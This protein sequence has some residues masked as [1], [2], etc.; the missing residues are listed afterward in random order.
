MKIGEHDNTFET[1]AKVKSQDFSV[2]NS[3]K[4]IGIL[5]N[6]LYEHKVR[7]MCQ[8]IMCNGRDALREIKSNKRI[9]VSIPNQMSP[10][11]KVKDFGPGI[12][13]DRMANVFIRYG[14]STKDE[15]NE[16]TGGLGIGAKSPFAYTDS[17]TIISITD[18]KKRTY[19]AHIGVNSQGRL[20]LIST[21]ETDEQNGTEINVAVKPGDLNEF[22]TSIY[23]A[24]YF[25]KDEEY[26]EFKGIV[27]SDLPKRYVPGIKIGNFELVA[28]IPDFMGASYYGDKYLVIIDGILYPVN[29]KLARE[30]STVKQTL[31]MAKHMC[32]LHIGNGVVEVA[33]SRESIADSEMTRT[34]LA[35]V[36]L[37]A[38]ND[39]NAYLKT[40]FSL[41]KSNADWI[42]TYHRLNQLVSVDEHAAYGDYKIVRGMV[43]SKLFS[44]VTMTRIG[45]SSSRRGATKFYRDDANTINTDNID[46]VFLLDNVMDSIIIQNKRI[47]EYLEK[48]KK[49]AV[50]LLSL[51]VLPDILD[52]TTKKVVS[53][54]ITQKETQTALNKIVKDFGA[55]NLS[56]LPFTPT[57]RVP[58]AKQDRTKEMFTIHEC[59]NN[60]KHP[61]TT[62]LADVSVK[63]HTYLYVNLKDY[64]KYKDEFAKMDDYLYAYHYKPCALSDDS[65]K[66]VLNGSKKFETYENWK[67]NFNADSKTLKA[68]KNQK[69]KNHKV[70][71]ILKRADQKIKCKHTTKM[72]EEYDSA[73]GGHNINIPEPII[74]L[75]ANEIASYIED[76]KKLTELVET[77]YPLILTVKEVSDYRLQ[78]K[79]ANELVFYINA[80]Q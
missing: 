68:A 40:E 80:K 42:K 11:F 49:G 12:S 4:I 24:A 72:I 28:S 51:K 70:I 9:I 67:K 63:A 64:D 8:E 31:G 55:Q 44:K 23:R 59:D 65:I 35:G 62:T 79:D 29:E 77:E 47:R 69:Y 18:G 75:V 48:N 45:Y 6:R 21:D 17:F 74:K 56:T 52:Q 25:W 26:P 27:A 73:K 36:S 5:R 34:N 30:V 37:K 41:V 16:Q 66:L 1:N 20:D 43:E 53:P 13:P 3:A 71:E 7:S 54:G 78:K 2:G 38:L 15:S 19:V 57:V 76:D 50:M 32:V 33:A 39:L 46:Q 22:R 58:R 10:V 61:L 60:G 14:T